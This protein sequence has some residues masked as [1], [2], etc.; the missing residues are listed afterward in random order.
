MRAWTTRRST[1]ASDWRWPSALSTSPLLAAHGARALDASR[2][3]PAFVFELDGRTLAFV[4]E[5]LG[6]K[7]IIARQVLSEQGIDRFARRGLRHGRGDRQRS[8]L[9]RRAAAGRERLLRDGLLGVVSR[10]R[11][12][13]S[14]RGGLAPG[15]RGRG[16]RVGGRRVA[17]AAGA[18][19][20]AGDRARGGGRRRRAGGATRR[21]WA[22]SW[23]LETKSCSWPPA[24]CTP[25]ELRWRV[26][27]RAGLADGYA[28]ALPSGTTLGEALL[29]PSAMYV[30]A[31][32]RSCSRAACR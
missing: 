6:T 19:R 2:G 20:R 1:R 27:S 18:R 13:R 32:A 11:A 30:G 25:T 22:R 28:T 5:G 14:L 17:L 29:E 15:V 4:V 3:E 8:V 31:G 7:S 23:V 24:A 21:S 10:G 16:L 12:R 9:R 26:W